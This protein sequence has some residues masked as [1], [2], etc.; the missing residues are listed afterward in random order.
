MAT[1]TPNYNL[2]RPEATDP[3]SEFRDLFNSNMNKIDNIGG[4]G[5]GSSI[6]L[7][8]TTSGGYEAYPQID[9]EDPAKIFF[10][11]DTQASEITENIDPTSFYNRYEYQM[12]VA[13]VN[14]QLKYTWYGGANI[15]AN[16]YLPIEIPAN[17]KRVEFKV[18]TGTSYSNTDPQWALGIGIKSYYSTA[19]WVKVTDNDFEEVFS[20][21]NRNDTYEGYLDL[22]GVTTPCYLYICGHGW[23]ATWTYI[24]VVKDGAPTGETLIKYKETSYGEKQ[25]YSTTEKV[26]GTWSDGKPL[27]QRNVAVG[28]LPNNA[29]QT[30]ETFTTEC[31]K[32]YDGAVFETADPMNAYPLPYN[33]PSSPIIVNAS[34]GVLKIITNTAWTGFEAELTIR[35]TKTTD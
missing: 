21:Q 17:A 24:R 23:N 7:I 22:T 27:Y 20:Y 19:N 28:S 8:E 26:I 18:T 2:G 3:I 31:L 6:S 14:G 4:G 1:Y 30:I 11:N 5:G 29:T 12:N 13:V 33:D 15:G 16:S 25:N 32:G 35:Y 34:G 9:K 10:L